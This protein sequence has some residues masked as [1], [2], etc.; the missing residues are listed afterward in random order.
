[1]NCILPTWLVATWAVTA[2]PLAVLAGLAVYGLFEKMGSQRHPDMTLAHSHRRNNW[3]SAGLMLAI[4]VV[5][6]G[7]LALMTMIPRPALCSAFGI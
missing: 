5:F 4:F 6:P 7:A 2:T 3:S 1:M